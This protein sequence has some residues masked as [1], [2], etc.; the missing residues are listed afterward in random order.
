M[1]VVVVGRHQCTCSGEVEEA[2]KGKAEAGALA[3]RVPP[4][5]TPRRRSPGACTSPLA[6]GGRPAWLE[7]LCSKA[8]TAMAVIAAW[9]RASNGGEEESTRVTATW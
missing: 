3:G 4:G 7:A 5:S 2:P 8:A 1:E 9:P 6:R